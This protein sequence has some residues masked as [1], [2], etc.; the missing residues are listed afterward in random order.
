[1][2][3]HIPLLTL[4]AQIKRSLRAHLRRLGFQKTAHGL[5][6]PPDDLKESI[7]ALHRA[8]RDQR[9]V[10]E[11]KFVRSEWPLLKS[12]FANGSEV[13]VAKVAAR[14]ELIS[15]DTWQSRLFRLASLTWSVPVSQGYGRRMRFLVWDDSN[16]RLIG[17]IALGDPVFNLRVRDELVGWNADDRRKRLVNVLD[18]YVLGAVPPYSSLLSGKFVACLVR[19]REIKQAFSERY[20]KSRGIISG[21]AKHPSLVMVT[22]TSAL[23]RSSVYNRLALGG[24]KY[25]KSV[26]FTSGWG[27][28]HIPQKL[29]E[30][31]RAYLEQRGHE[32]ANKN[33]YGDGPNWRLRAIRHALSEM[34]LDP[35]LLRHG[36]AREVFVCELSKNVRQFL[37]DKVKHPDFSDLLPIAEVSDLARRRWLEPRA[38]R[39]PEFR[40][41]QKDLIR[42]A[43]LSSFALRR[44]Q[45]KAVST[46]GESNVAR[47]F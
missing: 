46:E 28:F 33:R 27:H 6:L 12:H 37:S 22:T 15:A 35:K 14:I 36:I 1:M 2:A 39:R 21:E 31:V 26:G 47:K 44:Q 10:E 18:A 16:D 43:L 24:I 8:Q 7:R 5:L 30:K 29:F 23:G 9:L 41:W 38:Q 4:E 19:T 34:G 42:E 40:V 32:Y 3:Q 13:D 17:L 11:S 25:F 20:S 45:L